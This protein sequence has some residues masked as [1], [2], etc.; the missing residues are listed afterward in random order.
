MPEITM[1]KPAESNVTQR[2]QVRSNGRT[3]PSPANDERAMCA[4]CSATHYNSV[5][6]CIDLGKSTRSVCGFFVACSQL[7]GEGFVR[8][9]AN[10]E[11]RASKS[12]CSR[13]R[14]VATT[15]N[16]DKWRDKCNYS[17]VARARNAGSRPQCT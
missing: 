14:N 11:A 13:A 8:S 15:A 1:S 7:N 3:G 16:S 10:S 2:K 4:R 5:R 17:R 6:A 12:V 9:P